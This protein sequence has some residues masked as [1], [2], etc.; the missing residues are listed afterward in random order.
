MCPGHA[1]SNFN[2]FCDRVLPWIDRIMLNGKLAEPF[3]LQPPPN[4][5]L[6]LRR[7]YPRVFYWNFIRPVSQ[8]RRIRL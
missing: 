3:I 7:R 1:D 2:M 6:D 8:Q 5:L 4:R